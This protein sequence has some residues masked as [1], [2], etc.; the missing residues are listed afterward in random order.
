MH[1][2]TGKTGV[3]RVWQLLTFLSAIVLLA[4]FGAQVASA[5]G[6]ITNLSP[7][8]ASAGSAQF[9]MIVTA[10]NLPTGTYTVFWNNGTTNAPLQTTFIPGVGI[11][12]VVTANLV[13]FPG[14]AQVTVQ[15][16]AA[17]PTVP[18]SAA[19]FTIN[20]SVIT[21]LSPPSI[22]AGHATFTLTVNGLGFFN[23][24]VSSLVTF[25]NATIVATFINAT[26]LQ[27]VIP[28]T[29][30]T[31]TGTVAVSVINPDDTQSPQFPFNITGPLTITST[32]MATGTAG[33]LYDFTFQTVNGVAPLNFSATGLPATLALNPLT[34]EVLG[35]PTVATSYS[36]S[37]TVTD[38][39]GQSARGVFPLLIV[40]PPLTITTVSLPAGTVGVPYS[41]AVAAAGG[42]PPYTFSIVPNQAGAQLPPGLNL[43]SN[44]AITGTPTKNGTYNFAVQVVD[45]AT[46]LAAKSLS[47]TIGLP[48]FQLL[49][50]SLP[51]GSANTF[52]DFTF[53][54][55]NGV[56][57]LTFTA[58][59]LPATLTLNRATGELSGTPT[60][61]PASYTVG[62]TVSDSAGRT[63]T[64]QYGLAIFAAA[65]TPLS[66]ANISLPTGTVGVSYSGKIGA[67]GGT[68]PYTFSLAAGTPAAAG[69]SLPAGLSFGSDGTISGT[70]TATGTSR[71][72]VLVTDSATVPATVSSSFSI[73]IAPPP[74]S[75]TTGTLSSSTAGTALNISFGATGGFPPYTFSANSGI[76][77]GA[78]FNSNGTLT[79]TPA[80]PGTYKFTVFVKD[81]AGTTASKDFSLTILPPPIVIQNTSLPN[82]QVGVAYS[83]QLFAIN[84]QTPYNWVATGTPA[85]ITMSSGGLLS[86]TPTVDGP[87]TIAVSLTDAAG[88][89]AQQSYNIVIAPAPL[90]ITTVSLPSGVAGT[91]YTAT[92]TATG[93]DSPYTFAVQGLPAGVT[94]SA[95]GALSGTPTASGNFS[96]TVTV[97]DSKKATAT[98]PYNLTVTPAS[99]SI[100]TASLPN[101]TVQAAYSVTM[102]A[103]GGAGSNKWA[104]TGLPAGLSIS[105]SGIISGTP[106][107]PGPF[108][109]VVTVTDAASTVAVQTYTLTI[110]LP[111]TPPLNFSS[112]P[113][114][115][116][117]G[118]QTNV[119]VGLA[120]PYPVPVTATLTLVFKPDS[121]A[122]D[123]QVQFSTGGRSVVVQIPAGTTSLTGNVGLQIGTV[124]GTIVITAQ[125]SAAG[126]DITPTPAPSETV[127]IPASAPVITSVTAVRNSTG[128]TVTVIGF[129]TPRS[130]SQA[131]FTFAAQSSANLQT[132]SLTIP[133][134]SLFSAWY[135]SSASAPF[136]SQFSLVQPFNVTGSLQGITSVTVTLTD[137]QGNS[138][139][140]TANLQ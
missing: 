35:T 103:S 54:T 82:G 128:L 39:V 15:T 125:L 135:S 86:G 80:N 10:T 107:A 53:Q 23:S 83:V 7:S 112:L 52:Y 126:Q 85:G 42:S 14:T 98:K 3:E 46:A 50:T 70:P 117:P 21:S 48:T 9:N 100:T 68:P 47:I 12:A 73:T 66:F 99:I 64:G 30:V 57:P 119:Q 72:T 84:G 121:G 118:T 111:V 59:G 45:S 124:S 95:A 11:S 36:I 49:T 137:A 6:T 20:G 78:T 87:F 130:V 60:T 18:S 13:Q 43:G 93:G 108:V 123:P 116:S 41:S 17:F 96:V 31:T 88:G 127:P 28:G 34:G 79:G 56:A 32:T 1:N 122:D 67:A 132:S 61:G 138:A 5:Q 26:T 62:L 4:G 33:T 97:T 109:V 113:P 58:T 75:I 94:A 140:V 101:G 71:F 24:T 89:T 77:S 19:T 69:G 139:P 134:A 102:A 74:L 2:L 8:I 25:G 27:A 91:P 136:G 44:G 40:P 131:T 63:L 110:L 81:S 129:A 104:A 114:V 65:F 92:L 106:S 29:L 22:N 38:S 120:S 16:A 76:P 133:V 115:I 55:L 51:P 37:L 90:V 105:A